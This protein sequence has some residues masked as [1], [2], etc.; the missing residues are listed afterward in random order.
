MNILDMF[1]VTKPTENSFSNKIAKRTEEK[2]IERF[3]EKIVDDV[4]RTINYKFESISRGLT[5]GSEPKISEEDIKD[6]T[7][8]LKEQIKV[9][10]GK[11]KTEMESIFGTTSEEEKKEDENKNDNKEEK[12][13]VETE[14]PEQATVQTQPEAPV[15]SISAFGY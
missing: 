3:A 1:N 14:A 10:P 13:A 6:L 7:N 12:S 15:A 8:K 5:Y 2:E 11:L 9:I 4:L